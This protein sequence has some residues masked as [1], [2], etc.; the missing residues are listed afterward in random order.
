MFCLLHACIIGHKLF[1]PIEEADKSKSLSET[2]KR[3]MILPLLHYISTPIGPAVAMETSHRN[4][5]QILAGDVFLNHAIQDVSLQESCQDSTSVSI[6]T[7]FD[8]YIY[9]KAVGLKTN[10]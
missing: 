7:V 5:N 6:E 10:T 9:D 2:T 3:L 8:T 1:F 4:Q